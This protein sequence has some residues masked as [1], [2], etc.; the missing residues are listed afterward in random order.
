[1]G[2]VLAI[3]WIEIHTKK[4][5][6]MNFLKTS[7]LILAAFLLTAATANA[8]TAPATPNKDFKTITLKVKG[9][10]CA[11]DLKD[12]SAS[13]EKLEGVI[14][15]KA[16]K[17]GPT[18]SFEVTF[19]PAIVSEATIHAAVESTAGCENPADRPYKVKL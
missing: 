7:V 15:C 2:F 8:Q 5:G 4:I 12:I 18:S 14:S 3:S 1:M 6:T 19:N 9:V 16:L 11:G 10:T 13:V 17:G